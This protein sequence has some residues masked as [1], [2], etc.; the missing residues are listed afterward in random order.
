MPYSL[1]ILW[2]EPVRYLSAVLAVTFSALLI[3]VQ[4]GLLLGLLIYSSLP[5]DHAPADIWVTT[6]DA[7]SLSLAHPIPDA[8]LL[9]VTALP[10]VERAE[11]V[12]Q[13]LGSWHKPHKGSSES[14]IVIG[15]RLSEDALG[16]MHE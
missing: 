2:R 8:W 3:A 11:V 4:C 14:C 15:T 13:G 6:P 9:R 1:K 5:I 10:E 7:P 16:A 12:L